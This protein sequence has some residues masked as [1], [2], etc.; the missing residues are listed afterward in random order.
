[1]NNV[2]GKQSSLAVM[3]EFTPEQV[4]LIKA[5]VA[6]GATDNELKLFLYRCHN[7]G[8]DPLKPGMVHFIKYGTAPGSIVVGIDGFRAKAQSTGKFAGIARGVVRDDKGKC[9]GA[10]CEVRRSDWQHP[11]REE[12]S[13][14]EYS[15]GKAMW[16]KM[17]ETMIKKVAEAATLRMAFPD[18][19]GGIYAEE[20]MHQAEPRAAV[21][22][23][24]GQVETEKVLIDQA[25]EE[26]ELYVDE[27]D[28]ALSAPSLAD[29]KI[30]AGKNKGKLLGEVSR[31]NLSNFIDWFNEQQSKD[32][33][34]KAHPSV[35][36]FHDKAS[37]YL[38]SFK[39]EA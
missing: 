17:P 21:R 20:E 38:A 32:P 1:M 16:A 5:T 10:W 28:Q 34:F 25:N 19:F 36:E 12:V 6:K 37:E 33:N 13:L 3:R 29:Y 8:L 23:P 18:D 24:E 4:D 2:V 9:I 26:G 31:R 7:M 39:A 27:L 30:K 22:M 14:A 15:T 35:A 11:A